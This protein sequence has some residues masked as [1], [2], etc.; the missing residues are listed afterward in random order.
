MSDDGLLHPD[1]VR[2][3][4]AL[5]DRVET[6]QAIS[7]EQVITGTLDASLIPPIPWAGVLKA[8][9]SLG[10]LATRSASDLSSGTLAAGRMPALSGDVSSTAGTVA[11]VLATVNTSPGTYGSGS[12][13]PLV[14]V[15][16]K[17]LVTSVIEQPIANSALTKVDDTNVTLTLGGTPTTALLKAV[18][19]TL[20]WTGTLG[21]TRGGTGTGTAFTAGSV[22]FAGASGVYS[23]D[24]ANLFWDDANNRLGIG[25]AAPTAVLHLKAGTTAASTAPLKFTSGT[26]LTTAE[27]GAVEFLTDAFY[28]TITTAAERKTFAFLES[29]LFTG[30]VSINAG[31]I[32][33]QSLRLGTDTYGWW[34]NTANN[35]TFSDTATNLF[36]LDGPAQTF[37]LYFTGVYG[38][39]NAGSNGTSDLGLSRGAA[40]K[41]YVGN[42]TSGDYSGTLVAASVGI[43]LTAPTAWLAIKAGTAT[44]NTAPLKFT[45]GTLLTAAEAGAVEF[46]TDDYFATITTGAA[47]KAFVLDDGTRLTSGRVPVATTN[48][49]LTDDADMTFAT[50]TLTITKVVMGAQLTLKG[51]TVAALPAGTVGQVV[52]ATDLL[53]PAFL[54]AAVGGGAVVGPVFYN[55]AA[56]VA[57]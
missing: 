44:A 28:G 16:G 22:V 43:G 11:T 56:W 47:R 25:T 53:A 13:I 26:L 40:A 31:T 48:G 24:N 17:G 10:D 15:N 5:K 32:A 55:G 41:L 33:A 29:P 12:A 8:G 7:A 23:Q 14:T 20:G 2:W 45:S 34:R 46:L 52:Y 37:R 50:D 6:I 36:S 18:S 1:W 30:T 9:S 49:R 19:L 54:V 27:A 39:A 4:T 57:C 51:Y 3:L 38:W 35:W 42:G 21:V